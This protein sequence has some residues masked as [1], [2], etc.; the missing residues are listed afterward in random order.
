[1]T[2]RRRPKAFNRRH[3]ILFTDEPSEPGAANRSNWASYIISCRREFVKW[4]E[5]SASDFELGTECRRT[6]N[7]RESDAA[8]HEHYTDRVRR[9]VGLSVLRDQHA[10]RVVTSTATDND[11]ALKRTQDLPRSHSSSC[12]RSTGQNTPSTRNVTLPNWRTYLRS[13]IPH[14]CGPCTRIRITF[15][16]TPATLCKSR[17]AESLIIKCNWKLH[18]GYTCDNTETHKAQ[19][20]LRWGRLYWLSLTLNVIQGRWFLF[21]LKGRMPLPIID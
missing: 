14:E 7:T 6:A 5:L 13:I 18:A 15:Y 11:D 12:R 8:A 2:W 10:R 17:R 1:M 19:L 21:H 20:S 16:S 9:C 3:D 4:R